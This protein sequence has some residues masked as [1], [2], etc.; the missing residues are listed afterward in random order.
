VGPAYFNA[1][2]A[3]AFAASDSHTLAQLSLPTGTYSVFGSVFITGGTTSTA[4]ST[5]NCALSP[6]SGASR[7]TPAWPSVK[8][9]EANLR[10]DVVWMPP[11]LITV[12]PSGPATVS[13]ICASTSSTGLTITGTMLATRVTTATVS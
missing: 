5:L 13:V 1:S 10:D 11:A 4:T 3:T 9:P 12:M 7:L 2:L 8:E 6:G